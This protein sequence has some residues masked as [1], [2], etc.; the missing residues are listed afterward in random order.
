[1]SER[2][3]LIFNILCAPFSNNYHQHMPGV[4]EMMGASP[5]LRRNLF[6]GICIPLRLGLATIVFQKWYSPHVREILL[7]FSV[8]SVYVNLLSSISTSN[9]VWWKREV[10]LVSGVLVVFGTLG[11]KRNAVFGVLV[12]DVLFGLITSL[13]QKPW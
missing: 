6:Y 10:H 1:M 3:H 4:V 8:I 5:L 2:K 13:T 9:N 7:F 12:L 11:G